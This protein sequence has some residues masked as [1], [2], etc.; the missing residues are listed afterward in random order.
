[1]LTT[2][3]FSS[4]NN[5]VFTLYLHVRNN[6]VK[7]YP[8]D[9]TSTNGRVPL[10]ETVTDNWHITLWQENSDLIQ[11]QPLW[12]MTIWVAL[13]N[14]N[15]TWLEK[16]S[17]VYNQSPIVWLWPIVCIDLNS[18]WLSSLVD[19]FPNARSLLQTFCRFS[20]A[21][22]H[23]ANRLVLAKRKVR[24]FLFLLLYGRVPCG[25]WM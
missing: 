21:S 24:F 11:S 22:W 20:S 19:H 5:L 17:S 18:A 23:E 8:R 3:D 9:Q 4:E 2:N 13:S 25:V 7:F 16:Y 14:Y 6:T 1:M 12:V 15:Y 10:S